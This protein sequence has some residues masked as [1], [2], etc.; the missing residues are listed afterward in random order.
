MTIKNAQISVSSLYIL[1][2]HFAS[3]HCINVVNILITS[4]MS[5]LYELKVSKK[6]LVIFHLFLYERLPEMR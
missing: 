4:S 1:R 3:S 5:A 6:I 2:V